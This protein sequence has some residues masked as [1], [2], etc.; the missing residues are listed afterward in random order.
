MGLA[1]LAFWAVGIACLRAIRRMQKSGAAHSV[2]DW[3]RLFGQRAE[4]A[5]V[6]Q[7]AAYRWLII[8]AAF[9]A[10][11]TLAMALMTTVAFVTTLLLAV[12]EP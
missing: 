1:V 8:Q 11:I 5:R 10:A 7:P 12:L 4:Y 3:R 2:L 6:A 9:V